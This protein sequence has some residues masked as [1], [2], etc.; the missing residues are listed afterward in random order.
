[1]SSTPRFPS[2]LPA[3]SRRQ[4]IALLAG[5]YVAVVALWIPATWLLIDRNVPV[6]VAL[7]LGLLLAHIAVVTLLTPIRVYLAIREYRRDRDSN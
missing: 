3:P 2:R 1:M 4:R 6:A 5:V 7:L